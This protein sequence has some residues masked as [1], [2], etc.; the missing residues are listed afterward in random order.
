MLCQLVFKYRKPNNGQR[1]IVQLG[2][3]D[4]RVCNRIYVCL[5]TILNARGN[6]GL[7]DDFFVAFWKRCEPWKEEGFGWSSLKRSA[8]CFLSIKPCCVIQHN[9]Y[10]MLLGVSIHPQRKLC[11]CARR[12]LYKIFDFPINKLYKNE[13]G[14]VIVLF[15]A[16]PPAI[17][18]YIRL[19]RLA[20]SS[21]THW[22]L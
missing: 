2:P 20:V 16:L 5:I 9:I 19:W 4:S 10:F 1:Q 6:G 18:R 11:I 21:P 8:L 3:I 15:L 22:F 12:T 7:F 13:S 14:S 17:Y